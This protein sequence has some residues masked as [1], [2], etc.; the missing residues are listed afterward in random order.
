[1]VELAVEEVGDAPVRAVVHHVDN[2]AVAADIAAE[3][4]EK[5]KTP[6]PPLVTEMGPVLAVHL[7]GGA[8]AVVIE[9]L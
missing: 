6:E 8:V 7:G 4:G 5:L 1:M 9:K 3:V 2:A